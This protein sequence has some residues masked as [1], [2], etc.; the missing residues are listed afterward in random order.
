MT[1]ALVVPAI[2]STLLLLLLSV[3]AFA[4][5][6]VTVDLTLALGGGTLEDNHRFGLEA[7]ALEITGVKQ[8]VSVN[9]GRIS[10]DGERTKC[11]IEAEPDCSAATLTCEDLGRKSRRWT[12]WWAANGD[13]PRIEWL[14]DGLAH[15]TSELRLLASSELFE[16]CGEYFGYHYDLPEPEREEARQ[17]WIAWWQKRQGAPGDKNDPE[18]R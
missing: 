3:P 4:A 1:K 6:K 17:R 9:K 10:I 7:V 11:T 2:V 15:K 13:R 12:E 8:P 18:R 16:F 5:N 14:L